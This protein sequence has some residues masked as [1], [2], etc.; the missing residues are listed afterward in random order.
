MPPWSH[1]IMDD[2]TSCVVP[3]DGQSAALASAYAQSCV[4]VLGTLVIF[5]VVPVA[6]FAVAGR[7][8]CASFLVR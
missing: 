7:N 1:G 2:F 3:D 4:P 5:V 6:F 8:F